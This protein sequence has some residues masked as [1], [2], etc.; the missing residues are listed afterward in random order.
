MTVTITINRRILLFSSLLLTGL[1]LLL[2]PWQTTP[3]GSVAKNGYFGKAVERVAR[4]E[5]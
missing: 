2:I 5:A 1:A 3:D 4:G